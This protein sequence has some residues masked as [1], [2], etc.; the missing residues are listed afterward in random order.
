MTHE[1]FALCMV[2]VGP[3]GIKCTV[4]PHLL[5]LLVAA[6]TL[7]DIDSPLWKTATVAQHECLRNQVMAT[8]VLGRHLARGNFPWK[9]DARM[10]NERWP[11]FV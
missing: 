1:F 6:P 3:E 8:V 2:H 5:M 10:A 7:T 11:L 9:R 4:I